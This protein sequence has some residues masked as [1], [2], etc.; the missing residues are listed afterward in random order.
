[1]HLVREGHV[2]GWDDPR[3]PTL[4]GLRRRGY[5]AGAIRDFIDRA[6]VAK[7]PNVVDIS[8]LEHCV[9]ENLNKTALRVMGVLD[10]LKVVLTNYPQGLVEELDAV[11]NP[12]DPAAGSRKVPFSSV[13]YIDK[14]DFREVPP[15]KYFRLAPGKEVRLRYGYFIRCQEVV[16]DSAGNVIEL[17]CTYDPE[18]R[19]GYAP[20]GRKVQGTL[21]W[22]SAQHALDAEIRLYDRL[23][24]KPDPDNVEEG[25]TY[26]DNVN[27][28]AE[29][30]LRGCKVEPSLGS[31]AAGAR[32]QFER[33]G[34]FCLDPDT[35]PGSLV[36]NRTV[37]LR[38]TWAKIEKK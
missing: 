3:M 8:L 31:A 17:R 4:C 15:P 25:K 10:P 23:F 28:D 27:P 35:Q 12:E 5:P 20:D 37:E 14:E 21:H 34:Y 29:T 7:S 11:N 18:T 24:V 16:K 13:L 26:L 32:F 9:R 6:G 38:D 1:L 33:Q 36:F 30:V 22:V 2:R 19:G